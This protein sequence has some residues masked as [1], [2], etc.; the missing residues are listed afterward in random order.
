MVLDRVVEWGDAPFFARGRPFRPHQ[1]DEDMLWGELPDLAVGDVI[2]QTRILGSAQDFFAAFGR[3]WQARWCRHDSVRPEDWQCSMDGLLRLSAG[4][5]MELEPISVQLWRD[6]VRSKPAGSATGLDGLS[7]M[8]LCLMP[9]DLL[10]FM[11]DLCRH[12]EQHGEWPQQPLVG[13]VSAL[14]K[15]ANTA[16]VGDF[17]PITVLG[18]IY[19]TWSS[20]TSRQVLR[21]LSS[22]APTTL[23]GIMPGQTAAHLWYCMQIALEESRYS[24]V[25]VHGFVADLVKAIRTPLA[26]PPPLSEPG[27]ELW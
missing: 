23:H 9:T 8:D 14:E 7:R 6:T 20:I 17:R 22:F 21:Y 10:E 19:R 25:P 13:V 5:T 26:F 3:E 16:A 1:S 11:L 12:A 24:G 27:M 2:T 18:T 4:R 15:K